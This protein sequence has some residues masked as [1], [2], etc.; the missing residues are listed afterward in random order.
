MS[1]EDFVKFFCLSPQSSLLST[2]Y[3]SHSPP[4][5][6]TIPKVGTMSATM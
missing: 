6:L 3:R 1:A 2:V 4:I 5:M